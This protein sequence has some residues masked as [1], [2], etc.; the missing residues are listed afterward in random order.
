MKNVMQKN[1]LSTDGPFSNEGI[2]VMK[3]HSVKEE[4]A[5]YK[6]LMAITVLA[7]VIS[8]IIGFMYL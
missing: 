8:V 2:P 4:I 7:N 3:F 1:N 5:I 6:K